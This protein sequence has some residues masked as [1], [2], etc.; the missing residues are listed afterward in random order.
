MAEF[1]VESLER[2]R[3]PEVLGSL[4][5]LMKPE[6]LLSVVGELLLLDVLVGLLDVV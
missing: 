4:A 2:A 6:A 5:Q 3:P 1:V